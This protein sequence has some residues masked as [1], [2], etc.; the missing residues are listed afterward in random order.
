MENQKLRKTKSNPFSVAFKISL[1]YFASGF[2]WIFFTDKILTHTNPATILLISNLKGWLYVLITAGL[3]FLLIF[4]EVKQIQKHQ[5]YLEKSE[6]Q[7]RNLFKNNF[8]VQLIINIDTAEIIDANPAASLFYGY[9]IDELK[10]MRLW[11]INISE[12]A[13]ILEKLKYNYGLGTTYIEAKHNSADGKIY[14]VDVFIGK[15]DLDG[16]RAVH[17]IIH[18]I[19]ERKQTEW[20]LI[21]TEKR[22]RMLVENAPEALFVTVNRQFKYVNKMTLE[23]FGAKSENELVGRDVLDFV[24]EEFRSMAS[25]IHNLTA[26]DQKLLPREEVI[27]RLNGERVDV[28]VS[29]M[30][31]EYSAQI[32]ALIFMRDVT[33]RK[34]FDKNKAEMEAKLLQAQKLESLGTLAG[35]VAH[36]INN[37]I[38]GIINYA[39]LISEETGISEKAREHCGEIIYEGERIAGI[40]KALLSFSRQDNQTHS[41]A[42]IKDIIQRAVMLLH[43]VMRHDQIQLD[44]SIPNGLPNIKCRSQQIQQ[45]LMNLLTNARDALNAKY[46]GFDSDKRIMINCSLF[47]R[48]AR[49]WIRVAVEDNG[50]GIPEAVHE[51]LFDPFF[52]TK[53]RDAGTGLGLSVSHGIVKDHHGELYFESKTGEYTKAILE[54][55][56]DNGWTL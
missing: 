21:E 53:P 51:K 5:N 12:E 47:E 9:S 14:E 4:R 18:D 3:L 35:G 34:R 54:L 48:E 36:E 27:I 37:P 45:V 23:L 16:V 40:V 39:Q 11:D 24:D 33:D 41:P 43:T 38:N 29:S 56:V 2:L 31:I 50:T 7:Y 19:S 8:A 13:D 42:D 1:V 26:P 44:I 6:Q 49:R 17:A 32:G 30:L 15:I 22:F 55:P 28:E 25:D 52:T 46:K 10:T 20:K